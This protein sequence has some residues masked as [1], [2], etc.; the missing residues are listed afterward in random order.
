MLSVLV[1]TESYAND[2]EHAS[3]NG[4]DIHPTAKAINIE[5]V[6]CYFE[7]SESLQELVMYYD[8]YFTTYQWQQSWIREYNNPKAV[9]ALYSNR[10]MHTEAFLTVI[11]QQ[12]QNNLRVVSLRAGKM[13][14][15]L[16]KIIDD[17]KLG[18]KNDK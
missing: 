15:V 17:K 12:P 1:V 14:D 16:K 7:S 4:S 11:D 6:D 5:G 13:M 18:I 10:E 9:K 3:C 2:D 8:Q